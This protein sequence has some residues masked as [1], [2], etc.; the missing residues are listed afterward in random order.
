MAIFQN[1]PFPGTDYNNY[2]SWEQ[3]VTPDGQTYYQVPGNP[4]YVYDPVASAASGRRVFHANPKTAIDAQAEQKRQQDKA[5][6]Q[7]EFNSS[8][9]GQLLPVAGTTGG[10][11]LAHEIMKPSVSVIRDLGNGTALM[12]DGSIKAVEAATKT[13]STAAA[14]GAIGSNAASGGVK[15]TLLPPGAEV[16]EGGS[17]TIQG[18]VPPPG[19]VIQQ[20]GSIIDSETGQMVGRVVQ[21][22]L[23]AYQIYNGINSFKDD[24]IGG[25]LGVASGAANVGAALGSETAGS[26]AGPITAVKGGYDVMNSWQHGGEGIRSAGAE[27][28]AG[29][30]TM[31]AP[32]IGTLV[33]AA[34]G[35]VLG[36][37]LDKLGIMHKTTKQHQQENWG[38]VVDD[39]NASDYWKNAA[40]VHDQT[41]NSDMRG[42]DASGEAWTLDN[43][44]NKINSGD[45]AETANFRTGAIGHQRV[46]GNDWGNYTPEQQDD[47]IRGL[48]AE[49]LYK[50]DHGDVVITNEEAAKKIRDEVLAATGG[51]QSAASAAA[52]GAM[53]RS[54]T[55]SPGIDMNGNPIRY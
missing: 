45:A 28:G 53:Q 33:G 52:Q 41:M 30:G 38:K 35:N 50:G 2:Q 1:D 5:N 16:G 36:Y 26:F 39:P 24:K 37:G 23:G 44:I 47:I 42:K 43:V 4:G 34:A 8:P 21:G 48:A 31:I 19:K 27:L 14:Q 51:N 7:A 6:K 9:I 11:I 18:T 3:V 54:S 49:G 20:D 55:R 40:A 10:L 13:A 17:V 32:G 12:S 22:A 46:F 25:A 29:I 15:A